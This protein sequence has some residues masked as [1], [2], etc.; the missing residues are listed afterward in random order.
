MQKA[1]LACATIPIAQLSPLRFFLCESYV[2][3]IVPSAS[4]LIGVAWWIFITNY[5]LKQL[6]I[7]TDITVA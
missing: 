2:P 5:D 4:I 6:L 7:I 1:V 3:F